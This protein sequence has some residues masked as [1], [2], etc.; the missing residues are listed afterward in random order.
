MNNTVRPEDW[1]RKSVV[2]ATDITQLFGIKFTGSAVAGHVTVAAAATTGILFEQGVSTATAAGTTG[3]NPGTD[4]ALNTNNKTYHE[5]IREINVDGGDDWEAWPIAALPATDSSVTASA[6]KMLPVTDANCKLAGG[7][8]VLGDDTDTGLHAAAMTFAGPSSEPHNHDASS[9]HELLMV[10]HNRGT[11]TSTESATL[12]V[13][14]CDDVAG[15]SEVIATLQVESV[16]S[17]DRYFPGGTVPATLGDPIAH[18]INKRIVVEFVPG[19]TAPTATTVISIWGRSYQFGP[20]LRKDKTW[21]S[22]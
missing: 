6:N 18:A 16:I 17:T 3:T 13:H 21:S 1:V 2:T 8:A 11:V 10:H 15:T 7:Y 14:A 20:G 22:Y 19:T 5:I 9:L 4:G 12:K